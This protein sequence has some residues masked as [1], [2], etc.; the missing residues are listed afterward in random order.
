[1]MVKF[2]FLAL[3]IGSVHAQVPV[4]IDTDPSVAKGGHE[5]DD[6][7]ALIQ[8]FHSEELAIRGVSVVFGNA[9]LQ[10]AVPIAKE[11]LRLL[12]ARTEPYSGAAGASQLRELTPASTALAAALRKE[13]LTILAIGPV[14]NVATV[15]M[16]EPGLAPRI[17][18]IIAVAGRRPDQ[19]F[20]A[21]TK[22]QALRDFNFEMDPEAF[23]VLLDSKVPLVLAPWEISS[24]VW[25]TASDLDALHGRNAALDWLYEPAAEW[26]QL[27]RKQ[28]GTDGFNPFDTLAVA[29]VT[30]P[31]L[32]GCETLPVQIRTLPDDTAPADARAAHNKPYLLAAR[33]I[34]SPHEAQYCY[35]PKPE[36]K[37]D[38]MR[39]LIGANRA[40]IKT[41][42]LHHSFFPVPPSKPPYP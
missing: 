13:K 26:L 36:F 23:Q 4:W 18:R 42:H 24:K 41:G 31:S 20:I 40:S 16:R 8:A 28:F 30:S 27:W 17:E 15:L 12:K 22:L 33:N 11:L 34:D 1:M 14:T 2:V 35:E 25:L 7:F 9:P 3:L 6:G 32:I 21:G 37:A 5:V 38:L 10:T 29:V 19:R 39:R